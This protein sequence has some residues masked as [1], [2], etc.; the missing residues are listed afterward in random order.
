MPLSFFPLQSTITDR[1]NPFVLEMSVT[2]TR[3][4]IDPSDDDLAD[5]SMDPVV[6]AVG[7]GT[8]QVS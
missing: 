5:F 8:V 4:T 3:I 6:S 7:S 1:L 2:S